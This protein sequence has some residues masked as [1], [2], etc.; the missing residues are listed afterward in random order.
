MQTTVNL[1][2]Y[3]PSKDKQERDLI[4]V[5]IL[6]M[7]GL[8]VNSHDC[9]FKFQEYFGIYANWHIYSSI[10]DQLRNEGKIKFICID[11]KGLSVYQI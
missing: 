2:N 3:N 4:K 1:I 5:L 10:L 9:M 7:R 11:N 8:R 6:S